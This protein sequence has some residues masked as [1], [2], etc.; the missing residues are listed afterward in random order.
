[1]RAKLT[2]TVTAQG[3]PLP[4]RFSTSLLFQARLPR[5]CAPRRDA[6][7][8]RRAHTRHSRSLSQKLGNQYSTR[9]YT[10]RRNYNVSPYAATWFSSILQNT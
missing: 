8:A 5:N 1:M 2:A 7:R 3:R 10:K 4:P 6:G 9:I